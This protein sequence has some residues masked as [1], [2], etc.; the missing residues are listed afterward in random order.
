[1]GLF[2]QESPHLKLLGRWFIAH[3]VQRQAVLIDR[4]VYT[5]Y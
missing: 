3:E 1:M 2:D 5:T 4:K